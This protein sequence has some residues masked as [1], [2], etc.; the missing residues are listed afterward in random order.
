MK[1]SSENCSDSL[2]LNA[3]YILWLHRVMFNWSRVDSNN[4]RIADIKFIDVFIDVKFYCA[5][6][7]YAARITAYIFTVYFNSSSTSS[8]LCEAMN[9]VRKFAIIPNF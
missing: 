6:G 2:L 5:N 7:R 3:M 8:S 9:F 1:I 4:E